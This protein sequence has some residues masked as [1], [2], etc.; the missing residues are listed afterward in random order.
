MLGRLQRGFL[1]S[2]FAALGF[3]AAAQDEQSATQVIISVADQKMAVL[4]DGKWTYKFKVSTSKFGIGDSLGSYKTPLGKLRVCDKIGGNLAPGS[5]IKHRCCTGEVLP[6]NAPGRD[7]IVTRILWLEGLEAGNEH[8]K[9]RGI[10]IHGTVEESKIGKP[11]SYGCIRMRSSEVVQVFD[12]VPL[13]TLVTI[14]QERLPKLARWKPTPAAIVAAAKPPAPEPKPEPKPELKKPETKRVAEKPALEPT[15][16]MT[17]EGHN[18]LSQRAAEEIRKKHGN[19]QAS[20]SLDAAA[21]LKESILMA[22][23][24]KREKAAANH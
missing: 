11:V 9:A 18:V 19:P 10:Y 16:V 2:I 17:G 21:A 15:H 5:V 3:H 1:I 12:A 8:A 7:P 20:T 4:R 24:P 22:G 14:Q 23:L 13:G 6:V